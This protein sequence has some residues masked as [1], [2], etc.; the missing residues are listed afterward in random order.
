M[1]ERSRVQRWVAEPLGGEVES[2]LRRL[3]QADDVE[4]I[5]VMPDAHLA[6]DVCIGTVLATRHL[7]YPAA[8]GGDIGCG[9]AAMRFEGDMCVD[10]QRTA[11]RVLAGLGE[12]VPVMKHRSRV[13]PEKHLWS[14]RLSCDRLQRLRG[15]EG[16]VQLG[17]L[18]RGNHFLELQSD[19]QGR[20]WLMVHS[21]SRALGQ[22]IRDHHLRGCESGRLGFRYLAADT[23]EGRAYLGDVA[24]ALDYAK[25]NRQRILDAAAEVIETVTG[26]RALASTHLGCYHNYVERVEGSEAAIW[27]HRKGAI[28][29]REGEPGIIP[30]SMGTPSFHV[31]GRG[32]AQA[33]WSSS[34]GAGRVMSRSDA[35]ARISVAALERQAKGVWF[36]RR[37]AKRLVDEAPAAYKDI[38]KVMRAQGALTRIVRRLEP[39]LCYKG[40]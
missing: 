12:L 25:E 27:V 28:S 4:A 22:C 15:R 24:W 23:A 31:R 8:V 11:R 14:R 18:G 13:E 9:M 6:G 26:A 35:R 34:H 20:G 37:L 7:I 16:L 32:N 17:T 10:D 21:G 3:S 38:N 39:V 40:A 1:S 33:L 19:E 29:A 5:A 30:G 36:D 2:A